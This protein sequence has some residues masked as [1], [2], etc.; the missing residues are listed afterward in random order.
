MAILFE[1]KPKNVSLEQVPDIG[2]TRHSGLGEVECELWIWSTYYWAIHMHLHIHLELHTA[3]I[4]S[5]TIH[6]W[7]FSNAKIVKSV[8]EETKTLF[9]KRDFYVFTWS[10]IYHGF[11]VWRKYEKK[12]PAS[13]YKTERVRKQQFRIGYMYITQINMVR[14]CSRTEQLSPEFCL[15]FCAVFFFVDGICKEIYCPQHKTTTEGMLNLTYYYYKLDWNHATQS[16]TI[17]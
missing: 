2:H 16:P 1:F 3:H 10:W 8:K 4:F 12:T 15:W 14:S 5:T 13:A 6:K 7:I 11:F 9:N 17:N